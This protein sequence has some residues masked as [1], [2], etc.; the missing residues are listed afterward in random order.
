MPRTRFAERQASK[1]PYER[2]MERTSSDGECLVFHGATAKGYGLIR[3]TGTGKNLAVHRVVYEA[4][5]GPIP[6]GMTIDHLCFNRACV[7]VRHMEVVTRGENARRAAHRNPI[8]TANLAKTH[9]P[10]G[11]PYDEEN[12]YTPPSGGRY[13]RTCGRAA[14]KAW[15]TRRAIQEV[16]S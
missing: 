11:H 12:T 15:Y 1:T 4:E 2:V 10:Q 14:T 5:V 8:A 16:T 7:N 13:C 3:D 6:E 9:C